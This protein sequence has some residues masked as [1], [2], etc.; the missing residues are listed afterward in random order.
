MVLTWTVG[1]GTSDSDD[2]EHQDA[3]Y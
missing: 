3:T 1:I 2:V